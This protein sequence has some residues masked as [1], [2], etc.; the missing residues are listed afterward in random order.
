VRPDDGARGASGAVRAE[1]EAAARAAR[2]LT[3][4]SRCGLPE[5]AQRVPDGLE[6]RGFQRHADERVGNVG[7]AGKPSDLPAQPMSEQS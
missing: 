4:G 2:P 5:T 3:G 1:P 7:I 6:G